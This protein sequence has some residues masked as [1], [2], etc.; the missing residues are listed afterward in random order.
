MYMYVQQPHITSIIAHVPC[1]HFIYKLHARQILLSRC[2]V[3]ARVA[4]LYVY[5]RYAD[6]KESTSGS[7]EVTTPPIQ[8]R[9]EQ[10]PRAERLASAAVDRGFLRMRVHKLQTQLG[11]ASL[12]CLADL[13]EDEKHG[14]VTPM[15]IDVCDSYMTL[16]VGVAAWAMRA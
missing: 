3:H 4:H 7:P 1:H 11:V 8:L 10:G 16:Q 15:L 2:T 12:T 13:I 6:I 14:P 5:L 9:F